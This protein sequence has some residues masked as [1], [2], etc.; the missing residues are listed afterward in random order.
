MKF[1]RY[2][3][4]YYRKIFVIQALHRDLTCWLIAFFE[5]LIP[6]E[7]LFGI[8]YLLASTKSKIKTG[9]LS[10]C[11]NHMTFKVWS[12]SNGFTEFKFMTKVKRLVLHWLTCQDRRASIKQKLINVNNEITGSKPHTSSIFEPSMKAC[13]IPWHRM[14]WHWRWHQKQS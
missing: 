8:I 7:Q 12:P 14:M 9:M 4:Q 1:R 3:P 5:C 10:L 6:C 13:C 11:F 2:P